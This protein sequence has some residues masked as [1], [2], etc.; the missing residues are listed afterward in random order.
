[1]SK[2]IHR[3]A[4][5]SEIPA[6]EIE[7]T[8][9]LAVLAAESLHG[10]SRVRLDA[11]YSFARDHRVCVISAKTE[12]GRDICRLFTGF[13]STEFGERSFRVNTVIRDSCP[14]TEPCPA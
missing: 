7:R 5:G 14:E 3:Y 10:K 2:Q 6:D 8:L 9:L 12:V 13:A 11:S 4:F 1:M